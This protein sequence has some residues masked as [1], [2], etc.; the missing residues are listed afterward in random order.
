MEIRSRIPVPE[1][2][3]EGAGSTN[4]LKTGIQ[5]SVS[6]SD[7][8][9][10]PFCLNLAERWNYPSSQVLIPKSRMLD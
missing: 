4:N 6:V 9:S 8:M 1:R 5:D 2:S 10:D 7:I 3:L